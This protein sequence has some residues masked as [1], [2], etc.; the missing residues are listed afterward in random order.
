M[1]IG[2]IED[3]PFIVNVFEIELMPCKCGVVDGD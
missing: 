3:D 1:R 2:V